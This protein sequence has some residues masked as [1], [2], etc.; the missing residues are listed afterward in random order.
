MEK[1]GKDQTRSLYDRYSVQSIP[2]FSYNIFSHL[3]L[4]GYDMVRWTQV[5]PAPASTANN[6]GMTG[7]NQHFRYLLSS[8]LI[9]IK[10]PFSPQR[11]ALCRP[12]SGSGVLFIDGLCTTI[13]ITTSRKKSFPR[14]YIHPL[15]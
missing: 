2:V 12:F 5:L 14:K 13:N 9:S 8:L 1:R 10:T 15:P 11:V 7:R 4:L 3:N 6:A